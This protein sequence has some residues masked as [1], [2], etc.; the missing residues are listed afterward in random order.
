MILVDIIVDVQSDVTESGD[1][2][3]VVVSVYE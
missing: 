2:E 3:K 1:E